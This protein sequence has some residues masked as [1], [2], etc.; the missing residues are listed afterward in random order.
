M[1]N[2]KI[3]IVFII[4][5]S[6]FSQA[7]AQ[8]DR[9]KYPDP[10]PA[11]VINIQDPHTFTLDNGLKVF[12]VENHKLPKVSLSLIFDR[13]PL[14]EGDK[15]GL[16]EM[17]GSMISS[18][19]KNRTKEQFS[20]ETDL[21][22]ASISFSGTSA[23]TSYLKKYQEKALDLFTDALYNPVFPESE[24]EKLK[25]QMLSA[26]A[27]SKDE[28]S[29]ILSKVTNT[30]MYGK[31]HP[32]GENSSEATI[33]NIEVQ[34]FKN[35][36][37]AY[38]RPNI[39]YLA[40]VGDITVEEAKNLANQYFG[41]WTRK[42]VTKN[43]WH[44]PQSSEGLTIA[45]VDK[46][47]AK[48]S[49]IKVFSPLNLQ[50]NHKDVLHT[51][52]LGRIFGGGS[53]GRL[54]MNLRENKGYTYGAYGSI[55]P[56]RYWGSLSADANVG[57][58]VTDSAV[59]EFLHEI[60]KMQQGSVTQDELNLAKAAMAGS[61][62]RSLESPGTVA[63][64]AINIDYY[65]LN[66]DHYKSYLQRL[67]SITLDE[68]NALAKEYFDPNNLY[69]A[70]HG[71]TNEFAETLS[72]IGNIV[73]YSEDGNLRIKEE[74]D[75]SS[76]NGTEIIENYL[77]AIGGK[78]KLKAIK[79]IKQVSEATIQGMTLQIEM[80]LNEETK[81]ASQVIKINGQELSKINVDGDKVQVTAQGQE[82]PISE[83]DKQN[84][85]SMVTIIPELNY[86]NKEYTLEV[87]GISDI[88][89]VRA[90]EVSVVN[91]KGIKSKEFYGVDNKLKLKTLSESA[92]EILYTDYKE[93]QQ[94]LIP[95]TITTQNNMLPMPIQAKLI[96]VKINQ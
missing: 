85:L 13:T 50:H 7:F 55:S 44:D 2:S 95:T 93:F 56:G 83:E 5:L 10:A 76:I 74:F 30:I 52:L 28:P 88:N 65:N 4:C 25:T 75:S 46:P 32:Y 15:I 64:F 37:E 48:Q 69:I 77:Q 18:G 23:S 14:L 80:N 34:D 49:L 58:H 29:S 81:K 35:F 73:Y 53:S 63:N 72:K 59:Y 87:L 41:K 86:L 79:N 51:A 68:V 27:M 82:M 47:T 60:K 33:K 40:I 16:S 67:E 54:F 57:T 70:I 20:E 26:L 3:Y 39:A 62:G 36:H 89:G 6:F 45:L 96:E 42:E 91:D 66:K 78:D 90:Y 24:L 31:D 43:T 8:V 21:I 11:R 38:Y 9:S 92:G 12:V 84:Y 94:I 22:A 61:F 71:N 19:T 17:V 1:R